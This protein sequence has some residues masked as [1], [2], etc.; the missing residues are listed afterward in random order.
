MPGPPDF[1]S[2]SSEPQLT[3]AAKEAINAHLVSKMVVPGI[4]IAFVMFFAGKLYEGAAREAAINS[5]RDTYEET[6]RTS[7]DK[8]FVMARK[9][10]QS[11][12]EAENATN[13]FTMA[14]EA[15]NQSWEKA[16]S[17]S[18]ELDELITTTVTKS[19]NVQ[20]M[21]DTLASVDAIKKA[22]EVQENI[23]DKLR[24]DENFIK[25]IGAQFDE[26]TDQL[27]LKLTSLRTEINKERQKIKETQENILHFAKIGLIDYEYLEHM[28]SGDSEIKS[29]IAETDF[30]LTVTLNVPD[31][32]WG[33]VRGTIYLDNTKRKA[34]G[35]DKEL[36]G[37][38]SGH[39][40]SNGRPTV[41]FNSFTIVIKK[42]EQWALN[43]EMNS[44]PSRPLELHIVK[45]PL[46]T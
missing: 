27:D 30:L 21:Y 14:T 36:R 42:D 46:G 15:A 16:E 3:R 38:A 11:T 31:Q 8:I 25:A 1:L 37:A 33:L 7:Q 26:K 9:L 43:A 32:H 24:E 28:K 23:A 40:Q 19:E 35:K 4:V 41:Q 12:V 20:K 45:I 5:V 22:N 34:R 29:G 18:K 2:E 6:I 44:N 13:K 17:K 39:F 10:A